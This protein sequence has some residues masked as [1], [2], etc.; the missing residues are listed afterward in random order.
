M[1]DAFRQRLASSLGARLLVLLAGLIALT[2]VIFLAAFLWLYHGQLARERAFASQQ[3]S[4]L[5]Q[6]ALENAMVKRDLAGLKEILRRLGHQPDVHA[7][8]LVNPAGVVRFASHSR[9][10]RKPVVRN[11]LATCGSEC[12]GGWPPRH[13]Y[14][15]LME[16]PLLGPVLRTVKPI[17]NRPV[18]TPCHGP[19]AGHPVNGVLIVDFDARAIRQEA[20]LGAAGMA[21]AGAFITALLLL[22][23]WRFLRA[24]VLSPTRALAA[25]ARRLATGD[26]SARVPV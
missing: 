6:A 20:L 3:I 13:G 1:L 4:M 25:G 21:G 14:A 12:D 26:L 15:R 23:T 17:A 18:C 5:F 19:I 16:D 22:A 10:L 8:M 7:V 24:N 2:S 11:E 9:L